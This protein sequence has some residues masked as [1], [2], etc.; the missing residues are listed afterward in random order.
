MAMAEFVVQF[1]LNRSFYQQMQMVMSR[2]QLITQLQG[3]IED[4]VTE[5]DYE[6]LL[7]LVLEDTPEHR[8]ALAAVSCY[9]NFV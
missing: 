8:K 9:V 1:P 3:E 4:L 6:E 7:D 5:V 2:E